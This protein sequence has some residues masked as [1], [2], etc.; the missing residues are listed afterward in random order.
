M[1]RGLRGSGRRHY[2]ANPYCSR[3]GGFQPKKS[4]QKEYDPISAYVD[5]KRQEVREFDRGAAGPAL[6]RCPSGSGYDHG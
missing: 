1:G 3:M 5:A 4:P 6:P 2:P